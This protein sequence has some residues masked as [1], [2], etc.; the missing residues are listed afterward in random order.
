MLKHSQ[1]PLRRDVHA[2]GGEII[3]P[4][5]GLWFIYQ[6][7]TLAIVKYIPFPEK[8]LL[9]T[10]L[11]IQWLRICLPMQGTWVWSL[12]RELRS[13]MPQGNKACVQQPRSLQAATRDIHMLQ[14]KTQLSQKE[15][16]GKK[17]KSTFKKEIPWIGNLKKMKTKTK[18]ERCSSSLYPKCK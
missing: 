16:K 13:H 18:Q 6:T 17:K 11:M 12:V 2:G 1:A 4:T 8:T 3:V 10:S 14:M 9:G 15:R 5:F 7:P